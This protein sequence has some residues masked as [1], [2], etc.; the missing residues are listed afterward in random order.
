ML[1]IIFWL[2]MADSLIAGYVAWCGNRDYWND[3][4]FFKRY[5]PLTK[6]WTAWYVI[7]V[8]FIGYLVYFS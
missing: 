7:L 6:G 5:M 4:K 1:K 3:M 8:L 2:L